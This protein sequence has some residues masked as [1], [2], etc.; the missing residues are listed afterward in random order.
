MTKRL[1]RTPELKPPKPVTTVSKT[2]EDEDRSCQKSNEEKENKAP[3]LQKQPQ[4]KT[5]VKKKK[6]SPWLFIKRKS[7][8]TEVE[9]QK[10]AAEKDLATMSLADKSL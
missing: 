7:K 6:S 10:D 1:P 2:D 8:E 3:P 4:R 5:T 9:Q